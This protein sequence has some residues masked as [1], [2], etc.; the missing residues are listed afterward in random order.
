MNQVLGVLQAMKEEISLIDDVNKRRD[1]AAAAALG[2]VRGLGIGETD[3]VDDDDS[4][5]GEL[6]AT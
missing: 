2:L 1:A 6:L 5:L 4:E 3:D